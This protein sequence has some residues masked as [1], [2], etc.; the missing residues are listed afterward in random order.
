MPT[1]SIPQTDKTVLQHQVEIRPKATAEWLAR[2]P[3]A[4]AI[5]TA[6]KLVMALYTLN[7]MALDEDDRGALLAL[8]R[9]VIARASSNIETLLSESGIPP[10]PQQ[11]QAGTLLGEL[12]AEHS[13]GYKHLLRSLSTRR[14]GRSQIKHIAEVT[15][16]LLA[17]LRDAQLACYLTYSPVPEGLWREIHE[18]YQLA[19]TNGMAD[20]ALNDAPPADQVY[21]QALLL[22][23]ADPPHM[24]RAELAHIQLYLNAFGKLAVLG[25]APANAEQ[26]GFA[27]ETN[28]D[29]GPGPQSASPGAGGL[30]LDIEALCR[31]LHV[32]AVR[33]RTGDTP[34]RIGLPA[35]MDSETSLILA[36]RLLKLWRP[37]AH[38]AFK[39]YPA[40]GS[41][42]QV[43][44]GVSA[45]H[46]LLERMSPTAAPPERDDPSSFAAINA[47]HWTV[48]ND[49]AAGLA[50][51]G[52]PD[53]PLN[54]KVGDALALWGDGSAVWSLA[55]IR[56]IKMLDTRQVELGIERLSPRIQ[57]VWVRP[58]R[59][60]RKASPEPGL[61]L[62][63]LPAL[64]RPN[65]LLLPSHI[66]Q[67]GLDAEIRQVPEQYT[68]TFGRRTEFTPSF[69]LIDFTVFTAEPTP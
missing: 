18:L 51:T 26:N 38:R 8:Y 43:V 15:A 59:G 52:T 49:S 31:H 41:A 54:L 6:Q 46:R 37:G 25:A 1:F 42:M 61:F 33:L 11:R 66:Y 58:L 65:R 12:H 32:T 48:S 14:F 44:A 50:L 19:K 23:L 10:H 45:I 21:V 56:W 29:R 67:I 47:S 9:P 22:A 36:K 69:D 5:D 24:N 40:P 20:K 64:N 53:A 28:S 27:I 30:W 3:F 2:L 13:I 63:G 17:A 34:R 55:V 16:H 68:I 7:R 4:N 39:R 60:H 35:G 57:P 62:P